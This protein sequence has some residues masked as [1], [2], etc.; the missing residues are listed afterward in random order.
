MKLVSEQFGLRSDCLI[1][2]QSPVAQHT[3]YWG[4]A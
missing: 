4:A 1:K 2:G 3:N